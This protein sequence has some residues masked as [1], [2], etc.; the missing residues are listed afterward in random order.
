MDKLGSIEEEKR[1]ED[2][3]EGEEDPEGTSR[4]RQMQET[5]DFTKRLHAYQM[6]RI[7][8]SMSKL[9]KQRQLVMNIE[10][11]PDNSTAQNLMQAH[12][13]NVIAFLEDFKHKMEGKLR[14]DFK[15]EFSAIERDVDLDSRFMDFYDKA[16]HPYNLLYVMS[17]L[18]SQLKLFEL[19]SRTSQIWLCKQKQTDFLLESSV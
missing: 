19:L 11:I 15:L 6:V 2:K 12:V 13:R 4:S 17:R 14:K 9:S 5:E 7:T 18:D 3:Q 10:C 1:E 16:A 8:A